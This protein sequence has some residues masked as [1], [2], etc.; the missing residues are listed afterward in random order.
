[1]TRVYQ[2]LLS[3]KRDA[4]EL[5]LVPVPAQLVGKD[6]V[7]AANVFLP[8]RTSMKA[9]LLIGLNRGETMML[10]PVGGEAGP[11]REGD[12]LILLSQTLPDLSWL[13]PADTA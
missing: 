1:M 10:N 13:Q 4:N 3:V 5:Y 11:L 12:E 8:D 6:F 9:C 7:A 2:E